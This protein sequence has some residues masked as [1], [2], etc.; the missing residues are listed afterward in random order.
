MAA[1]RHARP[2]AL[3]EGIRRA[4]P[5]EAIIV[6]DL[7]LINGWMDRYFEVYEP[8][9]FIYPKGSYA[10][11][12]GLGAALGARL[13]A[14]GKP[15][16]LFCGDGGFMYAAAELATARRYGLNLPVV[17][18]NNSSY[19][20]LEQMQKQKYGAAFEVELNSPDFV[21][22]A[23]AFGLPGVRVERFEE[24]PRAL[25]AALEA[26][27]ATVIEVTEPL[28]LP[29]LPKLVPPRR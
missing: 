6:N 15:V 3:L 8:G 2:L 21:Q 14:P 22:L 7:A 29:S 27:S 20:I 19:G 11:G 17:V 4:L 26:P 25:A 13:G 23:A 9:A 10:L 12:F 5:R 28:P 24:V 18:F 1:G 16:V